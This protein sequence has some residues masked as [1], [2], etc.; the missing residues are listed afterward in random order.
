[1][2]KSADQATEDMYN[3]PQRKF[4]VD[5]KG[6]VILEKDTTNRTSDISDETR[7]VK[8]G[9]WKDP[10]YW[11]DAGQRRYLHQASAT[12]W[13]GFRVAQEYSGSFESKR[14]RRG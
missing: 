9:S 13:I 1:E 14:K 5:E 2:G 3:A 10:I 7:V 4:R 8:G 11:I 6:R 12:N